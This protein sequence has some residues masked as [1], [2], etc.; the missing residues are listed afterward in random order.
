MKKIDD[1]LSHGEF[2]KKKRINS[3]RK[4]NAFERKMASQLNERFGTKEFARTPGSGAYATTHQNLPEHLKILGPSTLK[5]LIQDFI[6][7]NLSQSSHQ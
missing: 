5:N 4:G 7:A 2:G 1:I 6:V 3:R